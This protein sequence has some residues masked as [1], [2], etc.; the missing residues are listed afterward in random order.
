MGEA[1]RDYPYTTHLD[2]KFGPSSLVDGPVL[3]AACRDRWYNQALCKVNDSVVRLGVMQGEYHWHEHDNDDEF[4]F[5]LEG[6][7]IVDLK[8]RIVELK[9]WQGFT[10]PKGPTL[11]SWRV[12]GV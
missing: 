8:D 2:I 4:L 12:A 7:F 11:V 6:T 1:T 5:V 9:P 3:V 10:V